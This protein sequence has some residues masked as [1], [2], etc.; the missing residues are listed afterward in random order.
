MRSRLVAL[1]FVA[2]SSVANANALH[3]LARDLRVTTYTANR[4][5]SD[6]Y[7]VTD[8][9]TRY[10]VKTR[11]CY[12]YATYEDVVVTDDHIFFLDDNEECDVEGIYRK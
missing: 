3:D 11:Y 12:A 4:V 10:I 2:V 5:D 8:Y 9:A 7:E 6:I 1:I